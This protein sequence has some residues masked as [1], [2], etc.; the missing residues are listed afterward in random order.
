M[1]ISKQR[2]SLDISVKSKLLIVK[3]TVKNVKRLLESA[4]S[5]HRSTEK[6]IIKKPNKKLIIDAQNN[7]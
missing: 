1:Y 7:Q 6:V 3:N 5:Q 2:K 4:C